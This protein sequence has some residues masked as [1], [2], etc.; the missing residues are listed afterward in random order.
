MK[1]HG[2]KGTHAHTHT[3]THTHARTHAHTHKHTDKHTHFCYNQNRSAK[4][5]ASCSR[6]DALEHRACHEQ[7][8]VHK[9]NGVKP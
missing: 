8:A 7:P 4:A 6:T 1:L 9:Q 2:H 5:R 3:H